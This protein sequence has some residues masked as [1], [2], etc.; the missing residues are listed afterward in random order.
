MLVEAS[1]NL[2]LYDQHA[3]TLLQNVPLKL[4]LRLACDDAVQGAMN[5]TRASV[6]SVTS[7]S[8]VIDLPHSAAKS[9]LESYLLHGISYRAEDG[10]SCALDW[11]GHI[12]TH[13][14][15]RFQKPLAECMRS[16]PLRTGRGD[17][18]SQCEVVECLFSTMLMRPETSLPPA[19][20]KPVENWVNAAVVLI[21]IGQLQ[22]KGLMRTF[23]SEIKEAADKLTEHPELQQQLMESV[24]M[25]RRE[26]NKSKG[27]KLATPD[28]NA[29]KQALDDTPPLTIGSTV[30]L[31][32]LK[33][34]AL[35]GLI[36][37]IVQGENQDGRFGADVAG[38]AKTKMVKRANLAAMPRGLDVNASL[39][40]NATLTP[41]DTPTVCGLEPTRVARHGTRSS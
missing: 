5:L 8:S 7:C 23:A 20:I 4:L 26:T 3:Q 16:I 34:T 11:L 32:G 38:E 29:G 36:G 31:T 2:D 6:Y 12:F 28:L 24:K 9:L 41:G 40:S 14:N 22:I 1:S 10:W 25:K 39:V 19:L 33:A 17:D 37:T 13:A 18:T 15:G 27:N 30:R 21:A 35:N